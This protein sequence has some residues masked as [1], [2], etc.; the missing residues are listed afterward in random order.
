M[1]THHIQQSQNK[2]GETFAVRYTELQH[3]ELQ[4]MQPNLSSQ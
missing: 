4:V 3:F 1:H 2:K